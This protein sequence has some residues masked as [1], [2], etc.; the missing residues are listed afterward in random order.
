MW[1]ADRQNCIE[2]LSSAL[3]VDADFMYQS[4]IPV[5]WNDKGY[6]N[7]CDGSHRLVFFNQMEMQ[8]VPVQISVEDY[9]KWINLGSLKHVLSL[10]EENG[11]ASFETP[12]PHPWFYECGAKE[13]R[14]GRTILKCIFEQLDNL[15]LNHNFSVLDTN[16]GIG[17]YLQYFARN[18]EAGKIVG[19]VKDQIQMELIT[20]LNRLFYLDKRI[21]LSLPKIS[22]SDKYDVVLMLK[23]LCTMDELARIDYIKWIESKTKKLMIWESGL[24]YENER[25]LIMRHSGFNKYIFLK[26]TLSD[27]IIREVGIFIK[28]EEKS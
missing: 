19:I 16:P 17:Y 8:M 22:S 24:D 7:I 2:L 11:A 21:H 3:N 12:I 26:R 15:E 6:F 20:W 1:F 27:N 13:E 23:I 9:E 5:R 10:I 18:N 4:A 25:E 14:F 28:E